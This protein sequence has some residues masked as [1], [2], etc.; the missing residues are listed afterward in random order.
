MSR[1]QTRPANANKH[2]GRLVASRVQRS[3]EEVAAE[4]NR[5]QAEKDAR[6]AAIDKSRTKITEAEDTMAIQQSA[7][8]TGP[9]RLV[10][11][12]KHVV[13][14]SDPANTDLQLA[15]AGQHFKFP[16]LLTN[17]ID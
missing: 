7:Q 8:V 11:P 4:K 14:N 5:K 10:R 13:T 12:R 6:T 2:P 16:E 15:V 17:L 9:P 1:P 3:K